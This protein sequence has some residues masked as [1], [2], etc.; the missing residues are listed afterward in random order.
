M[1]YKC[2]YEARKDGAIGKFYP[3]EAEFEAETVKEAMSA[4]FNQ[5]HADGFELNFPISC[6]GIKGEELMKEMQ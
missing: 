1:I 5:L 3:V 6:N 2:I 4:T